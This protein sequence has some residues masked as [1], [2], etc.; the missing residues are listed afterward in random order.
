MR[1]ERETKQARGGK[2]EE[3]F[4]RPQ[5]ESEKVKGQKPKEKGEEEKEQTGTPRISAGTL[6]H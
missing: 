6:L 4:P 2:D 1:T 3:L 5:D